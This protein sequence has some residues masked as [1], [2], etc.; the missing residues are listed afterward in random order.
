[1]IFKKKTLGRKDKAILNASCQ[2]VSQI[3]SVLYGLILPRMII[4]QYGSELNGLSSSISQFFGYFALLT[5]GISSSGTFALFKPLAEKDKDRINQVLATIGVAYYRVGLIFAALTIA[6]SFL[7][8]V[9]VPVQNMGRFELI[10]LTLVLGSYSLIDMISVARHRILIEAEQKAFISHL[11]TATVTVINFILTVITIKCGFPYIFVKI[12]TMLAFIC[13]AVFYKIVIKKYYS[14]VDIKAKPDPKGLPQ[15]G[16]AFLLQLLGV[17]HQSTNVMLLTFVLKNLKE[18]SVYSIYNGFIGQMKTVISYINGALGPAFGNI[19]ALNDEKLL[20][21]T[22]SLY[23]FFYSM[24]N[25]IIFCGTMIIMIPF[26]VLYTKGMDINYIRPWVSALFCIDCFLFCV[27]TPHGGMVNYAGHF[28]KTR[29]QTI[30][31]AVINIVVALI[32][33]KPLG[34]AGCLLGAI[35][36][37]LYR[38]I[39]LLYYTP[40]FITKTSIKKSYIRFLRASFCFVLGY[41]PFYFIKLEPQNYYILL[42][43]AAGVFLWVAFETFLINFLCEKDEFIEVLKAL[44]IIRK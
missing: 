25:V 6:L 39:D 3:C 31:Q 26:M 19:Y 15:R 14:Y 22:F 38:D 13:R 30:A 27:K 21:R 4:L 17:V 2:V 8:P 40:K 28:S 33:I 34:I 43:Q 24:F 36:S 7:Y 5:F 11:I 32:L 18:V 10:C 1:M 35:V 9:F 20:K 37:N 29:K 41:V 23:E 16:S 44:K 42:A 12:S